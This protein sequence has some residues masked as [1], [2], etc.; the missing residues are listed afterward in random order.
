MLQYGVLFKTKSRHDARLTRF[1]MDGSDTHGTLDG[2]LYAA[3]SQRTFNPFSIF[4]V[5]PKNGAV[6]TV[7]NDIALDDYLNERERDEDR[8]PRNGDGTPARFNGGAP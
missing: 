5:D 3:Y 1:T 8:P 7:M 4:S 2:A 6:A